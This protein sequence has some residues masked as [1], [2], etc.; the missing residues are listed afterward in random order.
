MDTRFDMHLDMH[1]NMHLDMR[2]DMGSDTRADMGS[3]MHLDMRLD[4]CLGTSLR[5]LTCAR[6]GGCLQVLSRRADILVIVSH[7]IVSCYSV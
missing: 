4:L 6:V 3:D 5:R 7:S 1:L 2:L